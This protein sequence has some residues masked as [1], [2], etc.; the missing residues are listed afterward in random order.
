MKINDDQQIWKCGDGRVGVC[1]R[2]LR[3]GDPQPLSDVQITTL[4]ES[5]EEARK[6]HDWAKADTLRDLLKANNVN[7][8]D[9]GRTWSTS[10][11]RYPK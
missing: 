9:K 1:F 3:S 4:L 10:D 11:G 5:R 7:L 8:D 6:A 2:F